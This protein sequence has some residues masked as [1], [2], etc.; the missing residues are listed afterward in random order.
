M[1]STWGDP[2]LVAGQRMDKGRSYDE[3][4]RERDAKNGHVVHRATEEQSD[5]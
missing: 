1:G 4:K 5:D 3:A 2:Q